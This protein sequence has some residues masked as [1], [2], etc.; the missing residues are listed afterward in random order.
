MNVENKNPLFS[1]SI[2]FNE[3]LIHTFT[4]TQYNVFRK[5]KKFITGG[6]AFF[7]IVLGMMLGANT[8]TGALPLLLG[9]VIIT[10]L[11]AAPKHIA[12]SLITKFN[13]GMPTISYLFYLE[14]MTVS[15]SQVPIY[16]D[17]LI[18]MVEDDQHLY[19]FTAPESGYMVPKSTI[20]GQG[21]CRELV[22]LLESASGA[23]VQRITGVF[24]VTLR[25]LI[26]S[27]RAAGHHKK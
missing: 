23:S 20:T 6:T 18:R 24:S 8:W 11:L 16:Y 13:H 22:Q 12:N 14:Q 15:S 5:K 25:S 7:L 9:C 27:I 1:A 2:R 19:L 10:N 3:E 26:A 4:T 21:N 17:A